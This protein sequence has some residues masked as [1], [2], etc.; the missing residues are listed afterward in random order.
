MPTAPPTVK[1]KIVAT[2]GPASESLAVLEQLA[3]AGVDVF[4]LN[5]SHGTWDWHTAT[6]GRIQEVSRKL[7]KPLAVLQDLCGPK[8]RL[9]DIAGGALQCHQGARIR[10]VSQPTGAS[11]ELPVSHPS[12]LEDL[13]L[14]DPV[15]LADG[16]VALRVVS[17]NAGVVEAE[18]TLPGEVRSRQG[19]S[20]P[21]ARLR[22]DPL[23]EKDLHDLDWTA[24]HDV[25]FIGLSFVRRAGDIERLREELRRRGSGAQIVAKIEKAEAL[26]DLDAIIQRTEAVMVARGDLGIEIDVARVPVVQKEIIQRCNHFGKPVITAT[27]MLESMRSSNRPTRAE[28]SDV[29][30]AILDGTDAVML[31]AETA[32]GQF[33]V[34]A[35]AT[36]NRIAAETEAVLPRLR[37]VR[38]SVHNNDPRLAVVE[39]A[40]QVAD[41][42]GARLLVAATQGGHTALALARQRNL[43]PTLGL[44]DQ[45]ATVRRMALYWGVLPVQF[46]R[47]HVPG[48]YVGSVIPWALKQGLVAKG[49]RMV[50]VFGAH[51]ADSSYNT[52]LVH[53]VV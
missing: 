53:E 37:A 31:S 9:G 47:P 38:P 26:A 28:A 44:S 12:L 39:C 40:G 46:A 33:P 27:Q 11:D 51:W 15:L 13:H 5:F 7:D 10:L 22:L 49:D 50:F 34:E 17:R 19:I 23:T 6:L 3:L 45:P 2:V 52:L 16:N 24:Q 1:T 42:V 48:E 41:R 14:G 29:A 43:T 8:L 36:M 35:V 18:V 4:R 30:N 21:G 32:T 20:V 25:D